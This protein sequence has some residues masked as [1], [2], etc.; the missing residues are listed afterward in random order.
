MDNY[1]KD[2]ELG[3]KVH[4]HLEQLG[5]ETPMIGSAHRIVGYSLPVSESKIARKFSEIMDLLC[6]DLKD[7]SLKKT[8]ERVARMFCHEIFYGLN[9]GNFPKCTTVENKMEYDEMIIVDNINTQSFCEHHFVSID[10]IAHVAYI[11]K[12]RV[13]GLSKI[14]RVV[15]FLARRPQI[16][17]RLTGQIHAA[18]MLILHNEDVA[19]VIDAQHQ[20]VK[21]RG[22]QDAN[23]RT[24]TSKVSGKFRKVPEARA[25][26]MALIKG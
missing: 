26:F 16:Q 19:V 3:E 1:A 6:L 2:P 10:G 7:D 20:C 24:V 23:S 9:Y 8:P 15:D 18:L 11:P 5:I 25:E 14:N 22:V 13:I 17:E 4:Q 21:S 12:N